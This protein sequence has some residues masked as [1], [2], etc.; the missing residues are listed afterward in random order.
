MNEAAE[1]LIGSNLSLLKSRLSSDVELLSSSAILQTTLA[2]SALTALTAT[3]AAAA[4][5]TVVAIALTWRYNDTLLEVKVNFV[6][7]GLIN[8]FGEKGFAVPSEWQRKGKKRD[9]RWGSIEEGG[10]G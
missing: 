5:A 10:F 7:T 2:S 3:A 1:T 9:E 6:I 8:R 4:A